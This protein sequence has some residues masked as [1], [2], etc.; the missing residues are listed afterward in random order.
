MTLKEILQ[1][2]NEIKNK[3]M[4]LQKELQK[5]KMRELIVRIANQYE[6]NPIKVIK[7]A[8]NESKLDPNCRNRN[9]DRRKTLD[10]GLF[11]L[12]DYWYRHIP[13]DCAYNPECA[14][15]VFCNAVKNKRATDWYGAKGI[16]WIYKI[17]DGKKKA[18][19]L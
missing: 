13:D 11:Q 6:I 17:I 15:K 18:V 12:N 4:G 5:Q 8:E 16:Y 3:I 10:R 2:I 7:V 14:T 1:K 9:K 19:L